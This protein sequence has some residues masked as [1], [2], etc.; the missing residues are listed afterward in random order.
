MIHGGL[1]ED[2]DAER[3]WRRPGLL[4]GLRAA[5][6]EVMAPDRDTCP[7]SWSAAAD[8]MASK[9][10]GPATV[11]A[12]S[13]GVSVAIRLALAHRALVDRLV[14]LWPATCGDPAL[15]AATPPQVSHLLT[16]ET[17]R[18]VADDELAGLGLPAAVMAA[19]PPSRFH[20][21][22]TAQR[23]VEVMPQARRIPTGF[24]EPLHP[25]FGLVR[26]SFLDA[27]IPYLR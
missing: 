24:P 18:G 7:P 3:F 8:A 12:G 1:G 22:R 4:T 20:T 11:V 27:V 25:D 9:L 17:L 19:D 14:L 6:F 16:G 23:L 5:G 26:D 13:N 21:E 10:R 2:I 15:D